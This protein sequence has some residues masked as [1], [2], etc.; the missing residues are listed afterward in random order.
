MR[1]RN[2]YGKT[3]RK[4]VYEEGRAR[5]QSKLLQKDQWAVLIKDHHPG[6][7]TW[8][9]YELIQTMMTENLNRKD[10]ATPGAARK[11]A[12]L[13]CGLLRCPPLRTKID[14]KLYRQKKRISAI[15]LPAADTLTMLNP[16]AYTS[17]E[18]QL[19]TQ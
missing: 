4:N 6:Y 8:K 16:N 13:L 19:M 9:E 12:A 7:V 14:N 2:A 18:L 3:A 17:Q 10:I 5:T 11:G 15:L 1:A